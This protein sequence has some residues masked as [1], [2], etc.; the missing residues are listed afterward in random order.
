SVK[1]FQVQ[2]AAGFVGEALKEFAGET[3]SECAGHILL[4]FRLTDRFISQF[5]QAAPDQV[6]TATE[7]YDATRQ[8]F[9]HRNVSLGREGVARVEARPVAPEA[10]FVA[11]SLHESLT[12]G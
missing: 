8:A 10:F 7:I 1:Q 4:L 6:W 11:Q 9:I 5:V 2:V 12:E 3:K